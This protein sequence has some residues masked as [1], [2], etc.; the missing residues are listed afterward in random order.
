MGVASCSRSIASCLLNFLR[1]S[2]VFARYI[3]SLMKRP[4]MSRED[5]QV[6]LALYFLYPALLWLF[7]NVFHGLCGIETYKRKVEAVEACKSIYFWFC[8][9]MR[10]PTPQS[11]M[12]LV[13]SPLN[14]HA[15]GPQPA[16]RARHNAVRTHACSCASPHIW[17][18]LDLIKVL[19]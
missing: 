1:S 7:L 14:D 17:N 15:Q 3:W 18:R 2:W 5:L 9:L 13:E 16:A 11:C 8:F 12:P 19:G 4:S 6:S 10:S